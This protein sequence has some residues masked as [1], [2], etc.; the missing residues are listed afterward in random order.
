MPIPSK[1]KGET[2]K[3]YAGRVIKT[4]MHYGKPRTQAIA[5]GMSKAG[6]SRKK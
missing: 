2:K 6:L 5:I 1:H 4:E 3:H